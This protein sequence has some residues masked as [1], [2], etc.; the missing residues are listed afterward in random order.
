MNL[1][2]SHPS[3]NL[4]TTSVQHVAAVRKP[5]PCTRS[6]PRSFLISCT[7]G[8]TFRDQDAEEA[9]KENCCGGGERGQTGTFTGRRCSENSLGKGGAF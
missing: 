1:G 3:G 9:G 4:S 2:V 5:P 6:P 7:N 8:L